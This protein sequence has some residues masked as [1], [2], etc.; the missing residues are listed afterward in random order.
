MGQ[1]TEVTMTV[2]VRVPGALN[3]AEA[4]DA[5]RRMNRLVATGQ[6]ACVA[7][8]LDPDCK[9]DAEKALSYD[10]ADYRVKDVRVKGPDCDCSVDFDSA[11][12]Y[13]DGDDGVY[14]QVFEDSKGFFWLSAVVDCDT[15]G[16][17]DGLVDEDGPYDC[18]S[19]AWLA[20]DY[21]AGDWCAENDVHP[22]GEC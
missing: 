21:A 1:V 14:Y 8:A 4:R 19:S 22:G 17:V 7:I 9:D 6:H 3:N 2:V 20:G 15:G 16:F 13:G 10:I 5:A 11:R 12:Y 18:E